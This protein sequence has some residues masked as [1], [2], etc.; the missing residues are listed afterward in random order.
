[1]A[2]N[3]GHHNGAQPR[4]LVI[5]LD[6]RRRWQFLASLL[7]RIV[8]RIHRALTAIDRIRA[9]PA[10]K[11]RVRDRLAVQPG[12]RLGRIAIKQFVGFALK[13]IPA[14]IG[15]NLVLKMRKL[16]SIGRDLFRA[17]ARPFL[18]RAKLFLGLTYLRAK[19]LR[20]GLDVLII[21]TSGSG[22]FDAAKSAGLAAPPFVIYTARHQEPP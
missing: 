20:R 19:C 3:L 13:P 15:R 4:C 9:L 22:W 7:H 17:G 6:L 16:E 1:M 8:K 14:L 5:V 10:E 12:C 21:P 18:R 11:A 2:S